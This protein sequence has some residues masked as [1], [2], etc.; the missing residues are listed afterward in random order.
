[1]TLAPPTLDVLTTIASVSQH[2]DCPSISDKPHYLRPLI[3]RP[4]LFKF[5]STTMIFDRL[6]HTWIARLK[7][8]R[9]RSSQDQ[10][11]CVPMLRKTHQGFGGAN[12]RCQEAVAGEAA[13][14]PQSFPQCH[15][16]P[17][18]AQSVEL[19]ILS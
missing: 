3:S 2:H 5:G 15:G 16:S 4:A 14:E 18:P 8:I 10:F 17:G 6:F 11:I 7:V 9:S 1:M 13:L 12:G 19:I